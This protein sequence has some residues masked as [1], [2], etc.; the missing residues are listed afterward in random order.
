MSNRRWPA[1]PGGLIHGRRT[2]TTAASVVGLLA[3][4]GD[5][6]FGGK[7]RCSACHVDPLWTEPGWNLH[8]PGDVRVDS[9]EADRAPDHSYKTMNLAGLFVRENG[10]FMQAANK[11][12]YH[13]DG[14]FKTLLDVVNPRPAARSRPQRVGEERSLKETTWTTST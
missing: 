8:K 2:C 14:R 7:A 12:R 13:H 5:D 11:G 9:F 1:G 10:L 3:L 4:A 6:L